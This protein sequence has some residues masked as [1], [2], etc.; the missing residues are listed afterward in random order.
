MMKI[1]NLGNRV[2]N[3]YLVSLDGGG[4]G[5]VT[6]VVGGVIIRLDRQV[7]LVGVVMGGDD[8]GMVIGL[9]IAFCAKVLV[10]DDGGILRKCGGGGQ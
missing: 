4:L 6:D 9:S 1:Y 2:V 3:N 10:A 5:D 7:M 8:G